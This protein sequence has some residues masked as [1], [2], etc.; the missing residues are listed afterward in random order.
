[1]IEEGDTADEFMGWASMSPVKYS[2][3]NTFPTFLK[4]LGKGFHFDARIRGGHRAMIMN[5]EYDRVFPMDIYPE[6]LIKAIM[7]KDID[8]MEKLGIYEVAPEDFALPE[9]VDT[10][11]LELQKM[12]REG[13]DYLR[14]ETI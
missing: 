10:S 9:F 4:G 13:L 14:Q 6:Y 7:A 5:N 2:V 8:R 3:H 1:M 11:K 12:V